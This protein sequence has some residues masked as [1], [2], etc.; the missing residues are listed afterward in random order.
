MD[1]YQQEI[2]R[3]KLDKSNI[4]KSF[5]TSDISCIKFMNNVFCSS[6]SVL[7]IV[8]AHKERNFYSTEFLKCETRNKILITSHNTINKI[9]LLK[10]NKSKEFASLFSDEE[11]ATQTKS[12][13]RTVENT[14]YLIYRDFVLF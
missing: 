2:L 3:K 14:K 6:T 8:K 11:E 9:S 7:K 10:K 4:I 12:N 5:L 1:C 13:G